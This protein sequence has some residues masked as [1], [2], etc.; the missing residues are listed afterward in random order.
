MSL[1]AFLWGQPRGWSQH[2]ISGRACTREPC[3][4]PP[5]YFLLVTATSQHPAP[6]RYR[7]S[8]GMVRAPSSTCLSP[9]THAAQ[10]L[11]PHTGG[12]ASHSFFYSINSELLLWA[13]HLL[14]SHLQ[15]HS[16]PSFLTA[17]NRTAHPEV[18]ASPTLQHGCIPVCVCVFLNPTPGLREGGL[19]STQRPREYSIEGGVV[20]PF[21]ILL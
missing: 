16:S 12:P 8:S 18:A 14:N 4:H 9:D 21:S 7:G 3:A 2:A 6:G 20:L 17:V 15:T 5:M 19:E 11:Q 10:L 1:A 13:K